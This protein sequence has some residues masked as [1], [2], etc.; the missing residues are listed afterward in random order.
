MG[1]NAHASRADLVS[2]RGRGSL[3]CKVPLEFR[4]S[5]KHG[6]QHPPNGRTGINGLAAE[7]H[8]MQGNAGPF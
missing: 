1:A 5:G 7:I 8:D 6:Q 3:R 2:Q 4:Y